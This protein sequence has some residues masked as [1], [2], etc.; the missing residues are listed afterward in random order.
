MK[1]GSMF[2]LAKLLIDVLRD[3]A[4]RVHTFSS[5]IR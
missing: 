3:K 4:A 2:I 5:G 1:S